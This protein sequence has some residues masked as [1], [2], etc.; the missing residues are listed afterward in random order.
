MKRRLFGTDGVRGVANSELTPQ[1]AFELGRAGAYILA[2][3]K[4]SPLIVVGKDTRISGDML[5]AALIAGICSVGGK[6]LRAGVVPTPGVACLTRHFEAD[7][8]AVISASHNPVEYNGIK[9]FDSKG[10]KLPD[11]IE[12]R[13]E[14][15]MKLENFPVPT[16]K[17][18]G[19]IEE[20]G[21][22][23][24]IY[25]N[26]VKSTVDMDL[27]GMRIA[28]DCANGAVY[29]AAPRVL[30]ELGAEV[31]V[32][33]NC[34]TGDNIN[35]KCGST[36]PDIIREFTVKNKADAGLSFDGDADRLIAVD[37]QGQI[38]TG[39][40]IMAVCGIFLKEQGRLTK[41]TV[42]TTVMSN[43]GL[44]IALKEA[45]CNIV[46]TKVG[47]RYVLEEM[48]K[49]GYT[50]GGEQSGHV[51]FLEHN[52]TGDG[53]ITALQLLKV[54]RKT[55]KPLSELGSVMKLM[56]QVLLNARVKNKEALW[57]NGAVVRKVEEAEKRLA[58]RGR[59]LVRP[60]GTEPLVR[61]M[62]EG[63]DER[64]LKEI[65]RHLVDI[66][67]RELN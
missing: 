13:I 20:I 27:K 5:E 53:L 26:F 50:F 3:G 54:M 19:Y 38:L 7:G 18:V 65:A 43:M 36:H 2:K 64:E 46:K 51:I 14:E 21:N 58:G 63:E 45:G 17:G 60:S 67:E 34:P 24:E 30:E 32:I 31:M 25:G 62:V 49:K 66:M 44:D 29:R 12:D 52:T 59:V 35:V 28:L 47:D 6:V 42:V 48:L 57:K 9:F 16:G 1:L 39:D 10:F 56:P 40:H 55:G 61:V 11:E 23:V 41:D 22:A 4:P 33:N 15:A 37:E 8:G